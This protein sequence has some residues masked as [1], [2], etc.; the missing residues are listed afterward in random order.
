M[1]HLGLLF[2]MM[3]VAIGAAAAPAVGET[4]S[5]GYFT[6]RV[7]Y[8]ATSTQRAEVSLTG[9]S[10]SGKSAQNLVAS[11]PWAPIGGGEY[12]KVTDIEASAF[13][14]ATNITEVQIPY[15][16]HTIYSNA[17]NGCTK[18]TR[19]KIPSSVTIISS[20][21]FAG[22]SSLK[23]VY[24]ALPDPTGFIFNSSAFPNNAGMN[25]YV[26]KL[27]HNSVE[28]YKA[29]SAF[30]KFTYVTKSK[31][32]CDLIGSDETCLNVTSSATLTWSG[33]VTLVGIDCDNMAS[34]KNGAYTPATSAGMYTIGTYQYKLTAI[35]DSACYRETKLKSVDLSNS[36]YIE[37]I[38]K[39]AFADCSSLTTFKTKAATIDQHAFIRCD[40][41]NSLTLGEGV[42]TIGFSAFLDCRLL[43]SVNIPASVT[44]IDTRAFERCFSL[45]QIV[46]NANNANYSSKEG[47]LYNKEQHTLLRCP[48]G[49]ERTELHNEHFPPMLWDVGEMAFY[50][51]R[52]KAVHLPHGTYTIRSNA[53]AS[54]SSLSY[55]SLPASVG[56]IQTRAFYNC[57]SLADLAVNG[58][59]SAPM[60]GEDVFLN[61]PKNRL[62]VTNES[63]YKSL[64]Q[65]KDWK[66]IKVTTNLTYDIS[67]LNFRATSN[68]N[69]RGR[70]YYSLYSATK[71]VTLFGVNYDG[72]CYVSRVD[73]T[74]F[75]GTLVIP[76]YVEGNGRKYAVTSVT[77]I[78]DRE[79]GQDIQQHKFTVEF[80]ENVKAIS[81]SHGFSYQKMLKS[82]KLNRGLETI[83]HAAFSNSGLV[84][85][86]ILPYGV[87]NVYGY[88]FASTNITRLLIPSSVT[89]FDRSAISNC[90]SLWEF[91]VN[92]ASLVGY[93]KN[94]AFEGVNSMCKLYVPVGSV[95]AFAG[96][97][98]W[99]KFST[100]KKGAYDFTINNA[101][102]TSPYRMTIISTTPITR[103]GVTY[104]GKAKYVYNAFVN[105][106]SPTYDVADY[107]TDQT[108]STHRKFLMTEIGDSCCFGAG[109]IK[110]VNLQNMK[111]LEKI[112][113]SA[114]QSSGITKATVPAT[115][116]SIGK[117]A[118]FNCRNLTELFI[119]P[120]YGA[121]WACASVDFFGANA[122]NFVCYVPWTQLPTYQTVMGKCTATS[123]STKKPVDQI[124][125]YFHSADHTACV[126]VNYPVDWDA[127]GLKAWMIDNY[128]S[129]YGKAYAKRIGKTPKNYGV[130]LSDYTLNNYYRL[131]RHTENPTLTKYIFGVNGD[132]IT[133]EPSKGMY[134][135]LP[136]VTSEPGNFYIGSKKITDGMG[137]LY[138]GSR[139]SEKFTVVFEADSLKGD[140]DGNGMVNVSDVTALINH[141]LGTTTW[142]QNRAD[143][144]GNGVVNVSDVTA[145]INL[146]LAQ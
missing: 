116:T 138:L 82:V 25:L 79:G 140:V 37:R 1:K 137:Y 34:S 124:D 80:G 59:S 45:K 110:N 63:R 135:Y 103:D 102:E 19:V 90:R 101:H 10:S 123:P 8:A 105:N 141:I 31:Y 49:L 98:Y 83:N 14:G 67:A 87:K 73:T 55:V 48:E 64:A 113:V 36:T 16:V 100:I 70:V 24:M 20:N 5:Y 58:H 132:T 125:A 46:V 68:P 85:D 42:K 15:G 43:P 84:G 66:A 21:A 77:D 50:Q 39:N 2:L 131:A 142:P 53:F 121:T 22:C 18:L 143:I 81:T 91:I 106:A 144:D 72:E 129:N 11:I 30:Q 47:I 108:L 146:I 107:E 76:D 134:Y 56:D 28:K 111:H 35:A 96:D 118:F 93:D 61:C 145:L 44:S 23:Y 115:V 136:T 117:Y 97:Q 12:C 6:Y 4:F 62:H 99:G 32:A 95:Q 75:E 51:C 17:F 74:N 57:T 126:A 52:V 60:L 122:A 7:K 119:E 27:D 109:S 71:P 88:A 41:L 40:A 139:Q 86:M 104:A 133:T 65:W 54:C 89:R 127:S 9:L 120:T 94:A 128:N 114:F 78:F 92:N 130:I 112:G 38:G 3:V 26:S 33:S 69:K 29:K 13:A